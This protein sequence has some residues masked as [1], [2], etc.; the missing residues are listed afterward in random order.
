MGIGVV[1]TAI[2][3]SS[4][5]VII[6]MLGFVGAGILNLTQGLGVVLGS[7]IGT[8]ITPWLIALVGFKM[9]IEA[10]TLPIIGLGAIFLIAGMRYK[11]LQSVAKF[12]I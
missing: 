12:I 5:I 4:L 10:L 9:D 3:Q 1:S 2:L 11:K 8:T 7:N 6:L